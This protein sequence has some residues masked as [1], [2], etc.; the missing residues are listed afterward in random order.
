MQGLKMPLN[1]NLIPSHISLLDQP[2]KM[3]QETTKPLIRGPSWSLAAPPAILKP[4]DPVSLQ[5]YFPTPALSCLFCAS[6][7]YGVVGRNKP[8]VDTVF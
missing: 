1:D 7:K 8:I 6:M 4:C 5:C 3:C 2:L